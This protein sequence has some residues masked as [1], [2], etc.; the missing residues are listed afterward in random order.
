[1]RGL[2]QAF[3]A[4]GFAVELPRLPGHGTTV[5]DM[6]TTTWADWS[7]CAE[8]AFDELAARCDR[9]VVAGLSM[10]GSLAVWLAAHHPEIAGVVAVNAAV[11][12]SRGVVPPDGAPAH[13]RRPHDHARGRQRRRRS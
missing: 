13:V 4:A 8:R 10:G 11:D 6:L 2:A 9:V 7:W 3:A 5:D 1:M 12:P